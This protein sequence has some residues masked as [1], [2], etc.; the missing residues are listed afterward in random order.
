[1]LLTAAAVT[2]TATQTGTG[3]AKLS[4]AHRGTVPE[5]PSQVLKLGPLDG[6]LEVLARMQLLNS[7]GCST[8]G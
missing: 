4:T 8:V 3:I 1:L 2:G 7:D 6:R 5:I